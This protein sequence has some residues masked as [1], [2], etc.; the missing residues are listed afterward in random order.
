M[1]KH[2][3]I[4]P[5]A[6]QHTEDQGPSDTSTV[7]FEPSEGKGWGFKCLHAHCANRTIKDVYEYFGVPVVAPVVDFLPS[8]IGV[9][10]KESNFAPRTAAEIMSGPPPVIEWLWDRYLPVGALVLHAAYMKT[11]KSTFT[12]A[13]A[14]AVAQG[15]PFLGFA[16]RQSGVLI[17]AVEE[18]VR[19]WHLRLLRFGLRRD[20]PIHVHSG[21]L[22]PGPDTF[23]ALHK[24]IVEHK[25]GLVVLDTLSRY[26]IQTISDENDNIQVQRAVEPFLN[27]AHEIGISVLLVH[28]ERKAGGEEGRGIRGASALFGIVDQALLLERHASLLRTQRVLRTFG[29]Y[30]ESP[31]ELVIELQNDEYINCGQLEQVDAQQLVAR[32][33]GALSYAP[34]DRNQIAAKARLSAKQITP[35]L[36]DPRHGVIRE[37]RGV[38]SDPYTYRRGAEDSLPSRPPSKGKEEVRPI[39]ATDSSKSEA[40]PE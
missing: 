34:Q 3:V 23:E 11:G 15:R 18:H 17:L 40:L 33:L 20:D 22:T 35:V 14:L 26:W 39:A 4:C 36:E 29:R 2:A 38:K 12:F 9:A 19:D 10:R 27:L 16:T 13:L 1:P 25:I 7:I 24:Y 6:D 31:P 8:P 21:P 32:V 30:S 37:G 28:H 5:W